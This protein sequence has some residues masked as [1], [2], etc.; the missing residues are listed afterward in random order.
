MNNQDTYYYTDYFHSETTVN[1]NIQ[2]VEVTSQTDYSPFGML[3]PNRHE[4][5][6]EYR[7]GFNGMEKDDEVS[8]EGNQYTTEYRQYD[9]RIGRWTSLDPLMK[10]YPHQSGYCAFNNNPIYFTDPTGLQG[11]SPMEGDPIKIDTYGNGERSSAFPVNPYE[12]QTVTFEIGGDGYYDQQNFEYS[13]DQDKWMLKSSKIRDGQEVRDFSE[14]NDFGIAATH[15]EVNDATTNN[16]AVVTNTSNSTTK[17]SSSAPPSTDISNGTSSGESVSGTINTVATAGGVIAKVIEASAEDMAK[18]PKYKSPDVP[19]KGAW[20]P[21]AKGFKTAAKAAKYLGRA[22]GV[23][24]I[25]TNAYDAVDNWNKG[26]KLEAAKSAAKAVVD[27]GML[28][29]KASP[30]GLAVS[31]GWAIV[32]SFW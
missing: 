20:K 9:P 24:S 13:K 15:V 22:L 5:S 8:G 10:Y 29:I 32:S 19:N 1:S 31:V 2:H 18:P 26:D 6:N 14:N 23:V 25:A 12:G 3:L 11:E 17:G 28:F 4:S 21:I 27:V 7:Y 30:V 16:S